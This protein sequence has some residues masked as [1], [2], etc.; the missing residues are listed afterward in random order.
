M[1]LGQAHTPTLSRSNEAYVEFNNFKR[2]A[3][4]FPVLRSCEL[5]Q[6]GLLSQGC[7]LVVSKCAN[8]ENTWRAGILTFIRPT[9][10][11]EWLMAPESSSL[12][13]TWLAAK[14]TRSQSPQS[15]NVTLTP[16]PSLPCMWDN[17]SAGALQVYHG[18][19]LP[20]TA[21]FRWAMVPWSLPHCQSSC[22][23]KSLISFFITGPFS[24]WHISVR[25]LET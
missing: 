20:A 9:V 5:T 25:Y 1:A 16:C 2:Q 10:P 21:L 15:L 23:P 6:P 24:M 4:C 17:G 22:L 11:P 12:L 13:R 8:E 14:V 3:G 7:E 18:I 19:M